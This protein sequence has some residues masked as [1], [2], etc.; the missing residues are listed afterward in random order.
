MFAAILEVCK[1]PNSIDELIEKT[2]IPL[3]QLTPILFDLQLK[4]YISQNMA[5]LWQK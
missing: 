5:G 2:N 3:A 4:G 1:Q